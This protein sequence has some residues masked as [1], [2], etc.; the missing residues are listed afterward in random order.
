[1]TEAA[2]IRSKSHR[3]LFFRRSP[4]KSHDRSRKYSQQKLS[5]SFFVCQAF[6]AKESR[7]KPQVF[8]TKAIVIVFC[9]SG[10]RRKRV[11]T[12]AVSI[13]NKS[14]RHRFWF[15]RRSPQKSHDRRRKY[16]WLALSRNRDAM[17]KLFENHSVDKVKKFNVIGD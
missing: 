1:M 3:L 6:A 13:H 10:V 15:V 8:T 16:S 9:L 2:S 5:S 12:E 17:K 4:Q 7:Q 14:Y 11:T